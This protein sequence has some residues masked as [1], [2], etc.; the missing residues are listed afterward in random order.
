MAQMRTLRPSSHRW[1]RWCQ[2]RMPRT[3]CCCSDCPQ[4]TPAISW[5][6]EIKGTAERKPLLSYVHENRRGL[7]VSGTFLTTNPFG[8]QNQSYSSAS[9]STTAVATKVEDA[10]TENDLVLIFGTPFIANLDFFGVE[11]WLVY[12]AMYPLVI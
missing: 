7:R 6:P 11:G 9:L 10:L 1:R 2:W 4:G 8:H 5:L 3:G 12:T